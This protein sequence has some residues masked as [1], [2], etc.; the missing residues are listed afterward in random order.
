MV[1][2]R[3]ADNDIGLKILLFRKVLGLTQAE[4]ANAIGVTVQTLSKLEN[5]KQELSKEM[6]LMLLFAAETIPQDSV[7]EYQQSHIV[8]FSSFLRKRIIENSSTSVAEILHERQCEADRQISVHIQNEID[9]T[10]RVYL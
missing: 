6:T 9:T 2:R 7:S 3:M 4:L 5:G 8:E 10:K 1:N